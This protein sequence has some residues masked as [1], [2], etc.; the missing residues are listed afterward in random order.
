MLQKDL[1]ISICNKINGF[2]KFTSFKNLY[3]YGSVVGKP[4]TSLKGHCVSIEAVQVLVKLYDYYGILVQ[5]MYL[6]PLS[7]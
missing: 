2:M 3:T 4:N 5:N 7:D 1:L 6:A